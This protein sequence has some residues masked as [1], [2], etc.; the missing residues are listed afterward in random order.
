MTIEGRR[1][2]TR[3]SRPAL[4]GIMI[5]GLTV[6]CITIV[7]LVASTVHTPM[8]QPGRFFSVAIWGIAMITACIALDGRPR[9]LR[10]AVELGVT[11]AAIAG[12][13]TLYFTG[14]VPPTTGL[15]PELVKCLVFLGSATISLAITHATLRRWLSRTPGA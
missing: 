6:L 14:V 4:E 3:F 12:Y 2:L 9:G 7:V 5:V 11:L 13:L 10:Y 1:A 8:L 15:V